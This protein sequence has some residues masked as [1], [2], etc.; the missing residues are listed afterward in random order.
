MI[1]YLTLPFAAAHT[2]IA[3]IWKYPP[4]MAFSSR[5]H[6]RRG[7]PVL[8]LVPC[9]TIDKDYSEKICGCMWSL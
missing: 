3:H 6:S 4:L 1:P 2:Y 8:L 7:N 5:A 9:S